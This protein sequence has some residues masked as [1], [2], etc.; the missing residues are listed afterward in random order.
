LVLRFESGRIGFSFKPLFMWVLSP[1]NACPHSHIHCYP[2]ADPDFVGPEA[3]AIFG[4]LYKIWYEI[5]YLFRA[6][7]RVLEGA[8]A[9]EGP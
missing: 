1:S 9:S 4:S 5:E 6:F 2:G 8:H 3:Y 7:P